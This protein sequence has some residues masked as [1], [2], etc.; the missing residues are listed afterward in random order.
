M[1]PPPADDTSHAPE[2]ADSTP[3]TAEP[4]GPPEHLGY[5][6]IVNL[7]GKVW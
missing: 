2:I 4:R 5:V 1:L 3:T 6:V 7:V